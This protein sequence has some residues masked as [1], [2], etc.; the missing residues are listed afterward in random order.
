M[1]LIWAA[2][3]VAATLL[4]ALVAQRVGIVQIRWMADAHALNILKAEPKIGSTVKIDYRNENGPAYNPT[5]YLIATIY[6][7]GELAARKLKGSCKLFSP[8]KELFDCDIPISRDFV[9]KSPYELSAYRIG[10]PAV[11]RL[12]SGGHKLALNVDVE[13]D[14]F[15]LSDDQPQHY[16]AKY[17]YDENTRQMV[18]LE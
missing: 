6:N 8:S 13:F 10:G 4:C 9:G 2:L 14:Y 5:C 16:S 12:E 1:P 15:G 18:K 7:E 11:G 3:G 17:Q